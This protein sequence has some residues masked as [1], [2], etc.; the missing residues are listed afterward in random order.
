MDCKF[1]TGVSEVL[2][3]KILSLTMG[4]S[5]RKRQC[6]GD[7]TVAKWL[8]REN[9][10]WKILAPNFWNRPFKPGMKSAAYLC[11]KEKECMCGMNQGGTAG[12]PVP[13]QGL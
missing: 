6:E 11:V 7:S 10:W 8:Q 3:F 1:E 13:Y 9:H 12:Y 4:V 2:T 5:I